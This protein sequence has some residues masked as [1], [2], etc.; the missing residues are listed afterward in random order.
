MRAV[1]GETKLGKPSLDEL[2]F[3]RLFKDSPLFGKTLSIRIFCKTLKLS[4]ESLNRELLK[5]HK[6][7]VEYLRMLNKFSYLKIT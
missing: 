2:T 7:I 5:Y 3:S 1:V 6:F 4:I